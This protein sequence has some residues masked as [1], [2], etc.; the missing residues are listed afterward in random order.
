MSNLLR[1]SRVMH[2]FR[3]NLGHRQVTSRFF[4]YFREQKHVLVPSSALLA[5]PETGVLFTNAGMNQ[6]RITVN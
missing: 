6:V 3:R 5:P 2:Q 4:D 1:C